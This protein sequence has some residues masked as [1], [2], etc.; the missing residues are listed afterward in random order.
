[1]DPSERYAPHTTRAAS[2]S[3]NGI[4]DTR[5]ALEVRD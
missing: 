4:D 2:K 1:M 5:T 3:F